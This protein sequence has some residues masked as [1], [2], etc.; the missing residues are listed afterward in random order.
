[1][2]SGCGGEE[3]LRMNNQSIYILVAHD[4]EKIKEC[5]AVTDLD[6]ARQH[7]DTLRQTWG[8][9]NVA[10]ASRMINDVPFVVANATFENAAKKAG[11]E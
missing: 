11:A 10:M 5:F 3:G 6:E 8:G 7:F 2:A 4:N 1:M 9:A